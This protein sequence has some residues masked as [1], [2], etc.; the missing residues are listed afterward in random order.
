MRITFN[1]IGLFDELFFFFFLSGKWNLCMDLYGFTACNSL[2]FIPKDFEKSI[3]LFINYVFSHI[4]KEKR[5][6]LPYSSVHP[7]IRLFLSLSTCPSTTDRSEPN[8]DGWFSMIRGPRRFSF[9]PEYPLLS[10]Y[11]RRWFRRSRL[12]SLVPAFLCL[13]FCILSSLL[14]QMLCAAIY[15]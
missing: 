13:L 12:T 8:L 1:R 6:G 5:Y 14:I 10:P 15:L 3:V 4:C 2:G 11:R 7:P 9:F